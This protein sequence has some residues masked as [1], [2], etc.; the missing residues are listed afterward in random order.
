MRPIRPA[1]PVPC[2]HCTN[3][4]KAL[5]QT[6]CRYRYSTLE[7]PCSLDDYRGDQAASGSGFLW[8]LLVPFIIIL[9]LAM[10]ARAHSA[11]NRWIAADGVNTC[12]LIQGSKS[13]SCTAVA[14]EGVCLGSVCLAPAKPCDPHQGIK[15]PHEADKE[16]SDRN[17]CKP[18]DDLE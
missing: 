10:I 11:E 15:N 8:M 9:A 16:L 12:T 4:D 5:W 14:V 3:P 18:K 7:P 17:P 2:E 1:A 6:E 13:W